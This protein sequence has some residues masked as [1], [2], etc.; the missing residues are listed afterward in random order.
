[1]LRSR[2]ENVDALPPAIRDMAKL[3]GTLCD[4]YLPEQKWPLVGGLILLRLYCPTLI[5]PTTYGLLPADH[6]M[7]PAFRKNLLQVTR[8]LQSA[9]NHQLFKDGS[10]VLLNDWVETHSSDLDRFLSLVVTSASGGAVAVAPAGA[11]ATVD[12]APMLEPMQRIVQM[13]V[14]HRERLQAD[15]VAVAADE[16]DMGRF[17]ALLTA[18]GN[19]F[20]TR[21][22]AAGVVAGTV[23]TEVL[24]RRQKGEQEFQAELKRCDWI[25]S[26]FLKDYFV[27]AERG[28]AGEQ[29][30][31]MLTSSA[32]LTMSSMGAAAPSLRIE[33]TVRICHLLSNDKFGV[34]CA[35]KIGKKENHL[36]FVGRDAVDWLMKHLHLAER[37]AHACVLLQEMVNQELVQAWQVEKREKKG[38]VRFEDGDRL[39]WFDYTAITKWRK[40]FDERRD[41]AALGPED[42]RM[43]Q[44]LLPYQVDRLGACGL[45][46]SMAATEQASAREQWRMLLAIAQYMI[47][48]PF[49]VG[50][51]PDDDSFSD[52]SLDAWCR[53]YLGVKDVAVTQELCAVMMT[54][55]FIVEKTA[56]SAGVPRALQFAEGKIRQWAEKNASPSSSKSS[57]SPNA[58]SSEANSASVTPPQTP[59]SPRTTTPRSSSSSANGVGLLA[60]A[61]ATAA[62]RTSGSSATAIPGQPAVP[63][64]PKLSHSADGTPVSA[65]PSASGASAEQTGDVAAPL[66]IAVPA[67]ASPSAG[68]AEASSS[69]SGLKERRVSGP[70]VRG[71]AASTAISSSPLVVAVGDTPPLPSRKQHHMRTK[72]ASAAGIVSRVSPRTDARRSDDGDDSS[73]DERSGAG[74]GDGGEGERAPTCVWCVALTFARAHTTVSLLDF[75]NSDPDQKR[76]SDTADDLTKSGDKKRGKRSFFA[77]AASAAVVSKSPASPTGKTA[78]AAASLE[79]SKS[80]DGGKRSVFRRNAKGE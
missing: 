72:S 11:S 52:A 21:Q 42:Q 62:G 18:C 63:S 30:Q 55:G 65:L 43:R 19:P 24:Q 8:L 77:K 17:E 32:P 66:T 34:P 74:G 80:T 20:R 68:P 7:T 45:L 75:L 76:S 28:P 2:Q 58:S 50:R 38:G 5:S 46:L 51:L 15:L 33:R 1:M 54:D 48:S 71:V 9:S 44:A 57:K 73:G 31:A 25:S 53:R 41:A 47:S 29:Q 23:L 4:R 39:F 70:S 14:Q 27:P 49:G 10:N 69:R 64:S 13:F 3:I 60:V 40:A 78:D 12:R 26:S 37:A 56:A 22:G 16:A 61:A 79:R 36:V 35:P 67:T 6:V 59:R